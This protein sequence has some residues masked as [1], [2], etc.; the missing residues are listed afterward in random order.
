MSQLVA[1]FGQFWE[2]FQQRWQVYQS[3]YLHRKRLLLPRN[4][5]LQRIR[6]TQMS[7]ISVPALLI[8][9]VRLHAQSMLLL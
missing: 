2:L 4:P 8:R 9:S 3:L 1:R 5:Q 7:P 6:M